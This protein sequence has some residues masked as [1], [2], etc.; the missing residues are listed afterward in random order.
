M[1]TFHT[2]KIRPWI[3]WGLGSILGLFTFLLQG[4][5]SVMIP[6][7][8]QTYEINVIQ[9]GVLTSSFFYTYIVMQVP[10]GMLVDL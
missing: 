6:Q 1:E 7:L 5:P 9:I 8:M 10:A 4:S 2:L 3:V